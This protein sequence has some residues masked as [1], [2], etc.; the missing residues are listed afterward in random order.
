MKVFLRRI[1]SGCGYGAVA[2]LVLLALG[3]QATRPTPMNIVSVLVMSSLIGLLTLIFDVEQLSELGALLLH[4]GGTLVLVIGMLGFNHWHVTIVF[5]GLLTGVY[6][7]LWGTV[8][9]NQYLK[10]TKINQALAKRQ[11]TTA[12]RPHS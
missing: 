10:V 3:V 2:Y 8:R 11:P 9:F 5:W 4:V 1:M 12:T 7:V 6:L